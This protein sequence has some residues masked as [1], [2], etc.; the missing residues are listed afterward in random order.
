[1]AE[2]LDMPLEAYHREGVTYTFKMLKREINAQIKSGVPVEPEDDDTRALR[3]ERPKTR[4]DCQGG[5]RP[6]PWVSCRFHL[7][8]DVNATGS[9]T[10][11]YSDK[12]PD[13][14]VETCSLD[15]ADRDG[16]TLEQVAD[17]MG[18]T[19]ERVRQ[20]QERAAFHMAQ[21]APSLREEWVEHET[22]GFL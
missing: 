2:E 22:R 17:L 10:L 5:I 4:G 13:E 9:L 19:R 7:Y 15:V 1:M 21:N 14:L 16:Q 20:I 8:L 3:A 12:E 18:I 11:P 6:C